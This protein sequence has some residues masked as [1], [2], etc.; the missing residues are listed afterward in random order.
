MSLNLQIFKDH[1]TLEYLS[2]S[3]GRFFACNSILFIGYLF[4][5][6][7]ILNHCK[8]Y[9]CIIIGIIS[10]ALLIFICYKTKNEIVIQYFKL[11]KYSFHKSATIYFICAILGSLSIVFI[12]YAISKFKPLSYLGK[13]SLG[14]MLIHYLPL[15]TMMYSVELVSIIS[16][17]MYFCLF[18]SG[19]VSI[20]I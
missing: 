13:Q 18:T 15:P 5:K 9:V 3:V 2:I 6:L 1:E 10:M 4:A 11:G 14:I 19:I 17:N 12:S 20:I 7:D 8:K 16:D